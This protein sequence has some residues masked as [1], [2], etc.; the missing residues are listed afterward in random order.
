MQAK[1]D[2]NLKV[3]RPL[4]LVNGVVI[5]PEMYRE[6]LQSGENQ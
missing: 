6:N 1:T 2:N 4:L 3:N 5:T